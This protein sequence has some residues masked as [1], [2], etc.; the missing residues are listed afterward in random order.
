MKSSNFGPAP[1]SL[2][3]ATFSDMGCAIE[4]PERRPTSMLAVAFWI[5]VGCG[6]I[7]CLAVIAA[8]A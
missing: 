4:R 8:R 7:G 5:L 1:R 2:K 3:E 6:A